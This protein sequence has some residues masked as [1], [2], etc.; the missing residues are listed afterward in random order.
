[1]AQGA[2]RAP[3]GLSVTGWRPIFT[4][5]AAEMPPASTTTYPSYVGVLHRNARARFFWLFN[6][7]NQ[8]WTFAFWVIDSIG[9]GSSTSQGEVSPTTITTNLQNLYWGSHAV[10]NLGEAGDSIQVAIGSGSIIATTG[11]IALAVLEVF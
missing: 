9:A 7:L 1:M 3:F 5:T 10:P 11:Q 6:T 8:D 2:R 4:F